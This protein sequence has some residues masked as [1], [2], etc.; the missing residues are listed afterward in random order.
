MFDLGAAPLRGDPLRIGAHGTHGFV[1][2]RHL[3]D[4]GQVQGVAEELLGRKLGQRFHFVPHHL[5]HAASA[6]FPSGFDH[7]AILDIDGSLN[8][9]HPSAV[10]E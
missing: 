10:A 1:P 5:S 2:K 8:S 4:F 6:Y 7:A 9:E 3:N